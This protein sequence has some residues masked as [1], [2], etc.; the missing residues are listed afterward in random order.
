MKNTPRPSTISWHGDVITIHQQDSNNKPALSIGM[1]EYKDCLK[2]ALLD[3]KNFILEKVLMGIFS[4][5]SLDAK[6][7]DICDNGDKATLG[8]GIFNKIL[9]ENKE[10]NKFINTFVDRGYLGSKQ[11]PH[12]GLLFDRNEVMTWLMGVHLA[13]SLVFFLVHTTQGPPG[14]GEEQ[15]LYLISNSKNMHRHLVW[16]NKL[17]A[18]GFNSNYHKGALTTGTYKHIRWLV[19]YRVMRLL[20]ALIKIVCPLE[21]TLGVDH[22]QALKPKKAKQ[23]YTEQAWAT[24]ERPW[25]GFQMSTILHQCFQEK[26]GFR[27]SLRSYWHF[28]IAIQDRFLW[29]AATDLREKAELMEVA[30][31]MAGHCSKVAD[32][33]YARSNEEGSLP[34]SIKNDSQRIC[35]AWHLM[36][37]FE[38][39]WTPEEHTAQKETDSKKK[40]KRDT[41]GAEGPEKNKRCS[42]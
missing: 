20:F 19:P 7:Q 40:R 6:M 32:M 18:G 36:L 10:S 14:R 1:A 30:D 13:W 17:G 29:G 33:H 34:K 21:L 26:I 25:T 16:D 24:L 8:Y 28:A 31:L 3:A 12:G 38:M 37:G 9:D 23:T 15:A 22:L 4:L 2:A 35:R 5:D 11:D 39:A 27:L 41:D 42:K